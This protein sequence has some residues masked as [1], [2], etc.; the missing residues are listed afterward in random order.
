LNTL[1][2]VGLAR[3][4][5]PGGL[6]VGSRE[7][8]V[9]LA[10]F[11]MLVEFQPMRAFEVNNGSA[12]DFVGRVSSALAE[13]GLADYVRLGVEGSELVVRFR[14][15]GSSE[16][17]YRLT[18]TESGFRAEPSGERI[19]PLHA[20]FRHRFDEKLEQVLG[21]VGARTV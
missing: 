15:M 20:A 13:G 18:T 17:R 4:R 1:C 21:Q 14:W 11:F 7:A 3:I 2:D 19:S 6:D 10:V 9:G 8:V 5:P 12:A 16:L